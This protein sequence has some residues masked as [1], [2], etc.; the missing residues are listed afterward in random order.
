[1]DYDKPR[2]HMLVE[3]MV[4]LDIPVFSYKTYKKDA[5]IKASYTL[6]ACRDLEKYIFEKMGDDDSISANSLCD[7]LLE[8]SDIAKSYQV[9]AGR[10]GVIFGIMYD[11]AMTVFDVVCHSG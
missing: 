3:D 6:H 8:Y 1:M 10:N 4:A 11:A 5:F 7:I 2:I 9:Y